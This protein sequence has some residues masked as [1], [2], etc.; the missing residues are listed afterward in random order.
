[1]AEVKRTYYS[2]GE[3]KSE[4]FEIN[5]KKMAKKKYIIKMDSIC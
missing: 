5:G 4:H 3:L 1:M 2:T